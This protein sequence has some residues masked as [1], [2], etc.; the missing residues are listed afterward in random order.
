MKILVILDGGKAL[1]ESH[2]VKDIIEK[3]KNHSDEIVRNKAIETF[4]LLGFVSE[5][6][7][8]S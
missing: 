1:L 8:E 2:Q 7:G 5:P 4:D 6:A 3:I